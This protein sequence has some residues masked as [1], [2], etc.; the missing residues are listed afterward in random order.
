MPPRPRMVAPGERARLV[1][2]VMTP[3]AQRHPIAISGGLTHP[4][5]AVV[6]D[7]VRRPGA[8]SA[9]ALRLDELLVLPVPLW[10]QRFRDR[11]G[12]GVQA[13]DDQD[14]RRRARFKALGKVAPRSPA[15]RFRC[16]WAAGGF[17]G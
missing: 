2:L 12:A 15:P 14:A 13:C 10:G 9:A 5:L 8:A 16:T 1:P 11:F 4:A 17:L 6:V 3:P 7:L